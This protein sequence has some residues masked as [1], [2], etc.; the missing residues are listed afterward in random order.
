[1]TCYR[2]VRPYLRGWLYVGGFAV[3]AACGWLD[4]LG[5]AFAMTL[6]ALACIGLFLRSRSNLEPQLIITSEGIEDR[7]QGT[8]LIRWR[9]MVHFSRS[10]APL[11]P[12]L[13]LDLVDPERH[14]AGMSR[15]RRSLVRLNRQ[16]GFPEIVIPLDHLS[17]GVDKVW[18]YIEQ[19]HRVALP[20]WSTAGCGR[21]A[22][23]W[24]R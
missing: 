17:P 6:A 4:G 19:T 16:M 22:E 10:N 7:R 12:H 8:G 23:G 14:L 13:R 5:I 18:D 20:R 1:M 2:S 21:P 15:W 3:L 11:S 24:A 9:D